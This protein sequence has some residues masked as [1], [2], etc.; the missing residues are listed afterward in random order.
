MRPFSASILVPLA[1]FTPLFLVPACSDD[2]GA[3][4]GSTSGATGAVTSTS[5]SGTGGEAASAS[6]S[7]STGG[8]GGATSSASA[9]VSS[10]ASGTGGGGPAMVTEKLLDVKLTLTG[11]NLTIA[12]KD[13]ATPVMTDAWLYTLQNGTTL[14][15]LTEFADPAEKRKYR[16][17]MMPCTLAGQPSSLT[18]CFKGE[19]NGVMTDV[20]RAKHVAGVSQSTIDGT[21]IVP[22]TNAPVDP[23]VVIV[24][25]EDQRYAGV[26]AVDIQGNPIAAP[27]GLPVLET[28][29]PRT[30]ADD[31]AP[32]INTYCISCHGKNGTFAYMPM[33]TYDEVTGFDFGRNNGILNC[34]TKFPSDPV[35]HQTCVDA[36]TNDE[37]YF[38]FGAPSV[39]PAMRRARP[40]EQKSTSPEGLAWY[41]GSS[42]FSGA[43]GDRRMP[44]QNTTADM[45]DDVPSP[46]YFDKVPGDYQILF[47]WVAQGMKP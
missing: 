6:S 10:S 44:P 5:S 4:G 13:G 35:A 24:A 40:D 46:T 18:P 9:S 15:P 16:G 31:A 12:V 7:G 33:D 30:Y 37:F 39:S 8:A 45:S 3:T 21:N 38:E 22:L 43:H 27:A 36:L 2:P 20:R 1:L 34:D 11:N 28:H 47:D 42:R 19:L 29:V 14:V 23:I 32:I 26:A 17:L 25:V 41:G